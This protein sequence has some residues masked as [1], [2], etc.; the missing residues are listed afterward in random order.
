M[1]SAIRAGTQAIAARNCVGGIQPDGPDDSS[2]PARR[3][4]GRAVAYRVTSVRALS[5]EGLATESRLYTGSLGLMAGC[6]RCCAKRSPCSWL[7]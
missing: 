5:T 1:G 6:S 4:P 3:G 7:R 2:A